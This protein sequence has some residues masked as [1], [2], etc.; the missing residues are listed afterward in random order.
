M[1]AEYGALPTRSERYA[2]Y[3]VD[4][5]D[6]DSGSLKD[7]DTDAFYKVSVDMEEK[8]ATTVQARFRRGTSDKEAWK[9]VRQSHPTCCAERVSDEHASWL[10]NRFWLFVF[11][12]PLGDGPGVALVRAE[13]DGVTENRSRA[14]LE[15][16]MPKLEVVERCTLGQALKRMDELSTLSV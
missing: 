5:S 15:A 7:V 9:L 16:I 2:V 4:D 11:D 13:W 10:V 14:E 12:G 1:Q 3:H 8:V 6:R